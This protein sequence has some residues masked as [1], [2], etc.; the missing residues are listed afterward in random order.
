M[1]PCPEN[2][3]HSSD[4]MKDKKRRKLLNREPLVES[5]RFSAQ[6]RFPLVIV[7][8]S[9]GVHSRGATWP[10]SSMQNCRSKAALWSP[11]AGMYLR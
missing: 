6:S 10:R 2:I 9:E 3:V 11:V 5:V 8:I 4:L 1:K 7:I